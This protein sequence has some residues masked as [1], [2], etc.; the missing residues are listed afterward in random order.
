MDPDPN[1]LKAKKRGGKGKI[2]EKMFDMKDK[3][4]YMQPFSSFYEAKAMSA[5]LT[6]I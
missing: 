4:S 3:G 6:L 5:P 1:I 2:D